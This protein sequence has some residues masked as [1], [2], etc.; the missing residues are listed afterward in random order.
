MST[1]VLQLLNGVLIGM[2][3]T[4]TVE[5]MTIDLLVVLL[6]FID[7][8]HA[9][10]KRVIYMLHEAYSATE[11]PT[12][13]DFFNVPDNPSVDE[14]ATSWQAAGTVHAR[15]HKSSSNDGQLASL[16]TGAH[17]CLQMVPVF[18]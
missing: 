3:N 15:Y 16:R 13:N 12:M 8:S 4:T 17:P 11:A 5:V 2:L 9:I 18:S 6:G 10:Q 7:T 1:L 14:M